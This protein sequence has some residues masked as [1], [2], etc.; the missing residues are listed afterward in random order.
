MPLISDDDPLHW[1]LLRFKHVPPVAG[2]FIVHE[3]QIATAAGMQRGAFGISGR[4]IRDNVRQHERGC[5]SCNTAKEL[6]YTPTL[7]NCDVKVHFDS[8]LFSKISI[9]P[10]I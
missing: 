4:N 2:R 10:R 1:K 6:R 8:R 7:G 5:K 9:D 3:N